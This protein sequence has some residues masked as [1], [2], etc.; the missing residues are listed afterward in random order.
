M[1]A[2]G[3]VELDGPASARITS[4]AFAE[5]GVWIRPM[6]RVVYLTPSFVT[7]E[8]ELDRL[9]AAIRKLLGAPN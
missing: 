9:T 1:G 7:S 6:G 2:I 5:Q 3:V 8:P 4:A